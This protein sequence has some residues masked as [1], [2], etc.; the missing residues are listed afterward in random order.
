MDRNWSMTNRVR[1]LHYNDVIMRAMASQ[2]TSLTIV[3]PKFF[4]AQIKENIKA[5]R[6]GPCAGNSPVTGEFP[7]Q[8]I[9]NAENVS[10][11]W[12]PHVWDI[13][14]ASANWLRVHDDHIIWK[15]FPHY[16]LF[17]REMCQIIPPGY[18]CIP[19]D[20]FHKMTVTLLVSFCWCFSWH[21][22]A[23][24]KCCATTING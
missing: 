13:K 7:T 21:I 8:R 24:T 20:I 16:W 9:S 11:W 17:V 5:P 19:F 18:L 12:R 2:I 6:H 1:I 22:L 15:R 4:Q 14:H 23:E 3:Y 10:T